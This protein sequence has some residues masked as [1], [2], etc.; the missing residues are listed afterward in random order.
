MPSLSKARLNPFTLA[1]LA[2]AQTITIPLLGWQGYLACLA[3]SLALAYWHRPR[4]LLRLLLGM[5]C[6]LAVL[7]LLRSVAHLGLYLSGVYGMFVI[8][9]RLMPTFI[10]GYA[11]AGYSA[12]ELLSA[13]RA[14]R[15]PQAACVGVTVFWC[16]LAQMGERVRSLRMAL[17]IRGLARPLS[18]PIRCVEHHLVPLLFQSIDVANTLTCSVIMK[19]IPF[20]C[21]KTNYRNLRPGI[22]DAL[23]LAFS[24]VLMGVL[25]CART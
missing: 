24:C 12:S 20:D 14:V 18:H 4:H 5:A 10:L 23:V 2:V 6:F 25:L 8:M 19:G 11:L 22:P 21:E 13:C 7:L 3:T 9:A 1:A 17:K 15:L 16:Y